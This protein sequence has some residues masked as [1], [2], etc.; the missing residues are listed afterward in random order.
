MG[1][2]EPITFALSI[3]SREPGSAAK[4]VEAALS[5]H[6][7]YSVYRI[8]TAMR[9]LADPPETLQQ[10]HRDVVLGSGPW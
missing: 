3:L 6:T 5:K 10:L 4:F 1:I 2:V 7:L 8:H 9:F